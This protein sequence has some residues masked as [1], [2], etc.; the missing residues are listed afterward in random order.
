MSTPSSILIPAHNEVGYIEP[1]LEA[2]LASDETGAA[3]E[4]IVMANGCSDATVQ[5]AQTYQDAFARKGWLLTVLDIPEGGK[6]GALNAGDAAARYGARIYVDADVVVTPPLIAQL[7]EV[8]DTDA[9]RYA[10]GD[11]IVAASGSWFTRVYARF[12]ASLPFCTHGVPGFG[13]FA[14]NA[15]ARARWGEFPDIISDDTFVRLNFTPDERFRVPAQYSWPMIEGAA[16]LVRV[17]R[18]QDIGVA[19]VK[20]L[21]PQLWQNHDPIPADAP[22]IWRRALRDPI[23]FAAFALVAI[24]V[25]LP[26]RKGE[27]WARGR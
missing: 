4:V 2:L 1:C 10:G 9:P 14:V 12:W 15:P 23:G 13:V 17:R 25:R 24:A 20:E 19:E 3:V 18:R 8:L 6:M 26:H 16:P 7:A 21:F 22:P 27:R 5:V 11:P